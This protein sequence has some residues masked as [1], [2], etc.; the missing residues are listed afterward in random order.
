M[1]EQKTENVT[2]GGVSGVTAGAPPAVRAE[3]PLAETI[4]GPVI[5]GHTQSGRRTRLVPWALAAAALLVIAGAATWFL[6]PPTVATVAPIR[7]PAV[8]AVYATGTVEPSTLIAIAGRVTA[9][10]TEVIVKEGD[11]VAKGQLLLRF[12]DDDVVE[13]VR[14]LEANELLARKEL[15]RVTTLRDQG[16]V[17]QAAFDRASAEWEAAKAA[18]SGAA[19]QAGYRKLMAPAAGRIV[20]RDAEVGQL[21]PANQAV[22]WLS[23]DDEIR[24]TASIDEEDVARIAVGQQALIRADAFPNEIF[25]G[26]VASVTPMGDAV[27]RSYRVRVALEGNT[28]L[29]IGMTTETNIVIREEPDALLIPNRAIVGDKVWTVV[30]GRLAERKVVVGVKGSE[31]TEILAGLSDTDHV[32]VP[33]EQDLEA[34]G[35]VRVEAAP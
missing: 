16:N 14:Q 6:L 5:A 24:I 29:L 33:A 20:K 11:E 34:G 8:E 21:I 27:A 12:E 7:G 4:P 10:I 35:R 3:L 1:S 25:R 28:P 31:R 23:G 9:R 19:V 32:V 18:R 2:N 26:R 30:D 17:S 15:D 22:L 13:T